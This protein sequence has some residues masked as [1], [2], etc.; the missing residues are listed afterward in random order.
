MNPWKKL[1][2]KCTVSAAVAVFA[3]SVSAGCTSGPWK[4]LHDDDWVLETMNGTPLPEDSPEITLSFG[5]DGRVTGSAGC[6][7]YLGN[8]S[9]TASDNT[10]RIGPISRTE[11][12]CLPHEIM[13]QESRF[14]ELLT[15]AAVYAVTGDR[16][17]LRTPD[18]TTVLVF[19]E[20]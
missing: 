18:G 3:A 4:V 9:Y 13:E 6:N 14:M 2:R 8:Y 5:A 10:I 7:T 20:E 16:L 15:T 12:I 11:K 17:E 19:I 1:R